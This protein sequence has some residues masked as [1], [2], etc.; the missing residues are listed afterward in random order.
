MLG[1]VL[2]RPNAPRA[3]SRVCCALATSFGGSE[4][5]GCALVDGPA[6][7]AIS[8]ATQRTV[9]PTV[10]ATY[11]F[12]EAQVDSVLPFGR[13]KGLELISTVPTVCSSECAHGSQRSSVRTGKSPSIHVV[14][15]STVSRHWTLHLWH[16]R[17]K[18]PGTPEPTCRWHACSFPPSRISPTELLAIRTSSVHRTWPS[19]RNRSSHSSQSP[20]EAPRFLEVL[21]SPELPGKQTAP[22]GP[23]EAASA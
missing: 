18:L 1:G 15:T 9:A 20:S 22:S 21:A 16:G 5:A 17:T 8:A 7:R 19:R 3:S 12:R 13:F 2:N 10:P 6:V 23:C 14:R 11:F 4:L